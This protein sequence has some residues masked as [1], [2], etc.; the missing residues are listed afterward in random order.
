M[1]AVLSSDDVNRHAHVPPSTHHAGLFAYHGVWAPG[2]RLFRELRFSAKALIVSC[3]FLIPVALLA[4]NFLKDKAD[5]IEF[6]TKERI[7]VQYLRATVPLVQLGQT[8]R[9][10]ALLTNAKGEAMPEVADARKAL[11]IQMQKVDAAEQS[12]GA[13]LGTAKA[14]AAV[15]AA[16][17]AATHT[18]ADKAFAAYSAYIDA[19][20]ALIGQATD[21]SNLTLD[22]DL[23]TYYLMDVSVGA[24]PILSEGAAKLRDVST[25][26]AASGK[27]V[28]DEDQRLIVASAVTAELFEARVEAGLNKVFGIHGDYQADFKIGDLLPRLRA[29]RELALSGKAE[30]GSLVDNGGAVVNALADAQGKMIDRL[31]ELLK[32]RVDGLA[33]QRVLVMTAVTVALLLGGYLFYSFYL[34]MEAGL[35]E[36]RHH[37]RA[38]TGGDLTTS[39]SP[40]GK[41]EAAQ[42][43][44][45][46]RDMQASLRGMVLRVRRSSDQ[47]VHSSSEI[48]S[49]AMD[50]SGRTEQAAANLEQSAASMEEISSTVKATSGHTDEASSVAR[51]NAEA[52]TEGGRVMHEVAATMEGIR[53]SSGKISEIIGTI[54][55]IAF[56]TNILALNAAVEAARAGEQGRGFAVVASEVRTLAQ[57]SAAA[58]REIKTLIGASVEQVEVGT[59]V[60]R[61]AG[62]SIEDIV[63]SSQR[64]DQLLGEVATGAREQTLGIGQIGQAVQEL[65][66]MTQQNAALVEQTAAAASAMKDQAH[67]LAEEVSRFKM[68]EGLDL[69][70]DD[71][72]EQT[73]DFD[74]DKAIEAHRQWKVKLRKAIADRDR[75]DADTLC[76]DDHCALGKWIHGPGGVRWGTKPSFVD[77]QGRHAEFH[78]SAG[79]VARKINGGQYADAERLIGS[80]SQFAQV[81]TEVSTLLTQ[82]KRGM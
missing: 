2:V 35:G 34:V 57:R 10:R 39:P 52:A 78:E 46:L 75:L 45:E 6:S 70:A 43:M 68:P 56:Q 30:R 63:S 51:R 72:Q 60:V 69:P 66:R 32:A 37:L 67:T 77:L 40:S 8:L 58:A 44:F 53:A 20:V 50:L 1:S 17:D 62:A 28:R 81:S 19:V 61:K 11:D 80:G 48:A 38:I 16:A 49:G 22:P 14:L 4:W 3:V 5:A 33:R 13:D 36:A 23:D 71:A 25:A 41:D 54:D 26:V 12:F 82:A 29:F 55:S 24:A 65:D 42:L 9:Q 47:I 15:K 7:G 73:T 76:R 21:G 74:F 18:S 59:A 27:P 64:V 79:A 31:D